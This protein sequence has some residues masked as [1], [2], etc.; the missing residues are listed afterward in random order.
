MISVAVLSARKLDVLALKNGLAALLPPLHLVTSAVAHHGSEALGVG[1]RVST[2]V[3]E[4]SESQETARASSEKAEKV[5]SARKGS[6]VAAR[7]VASSR[8]RD[9]DWSQV[10]SP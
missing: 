7:V 9:D 2:T 1:C 6:Q 3:Y 5:G 4:S 8:S 10:A